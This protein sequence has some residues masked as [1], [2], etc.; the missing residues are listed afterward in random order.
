MV[1]RREGDGCCQC[2]RKKSHDDAIICCVLQ[3]ML[4]DAAVPIYRCLLLF[5]VVLYDV[6][7]RMK[8][9]VV[10]LAKDIQGTVLHFSSALDAF[11][12]VDFA[13]SS[14]LWFVV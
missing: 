1:G 5:A 12:A 10:L 2:A 4:L 14:I 11:A 13:S 3:L 7:A 9:P 6:A 8:D